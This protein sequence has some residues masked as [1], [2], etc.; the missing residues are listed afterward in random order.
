MFSFPFV[1]GLYAPAVSNSI[2][3]EK[4][5]KNHTEPSYLDLKQTS[6]NLERVRILPN[7]SNIAGSPNP[8]GSAPF[9]KEN[10]L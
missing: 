5:T 8:R 4:I 9:R 3:N 6:R 7:I 10:R 2:S 1:S